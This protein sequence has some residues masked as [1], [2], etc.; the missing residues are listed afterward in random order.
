MPSV[1][2]PTAPNGQAPPPHTNG[3]GATTLSDD[4]VARLIVL[5]GIERVRR[6]LTEFE[7]PTLPLA[8]EAVEFTS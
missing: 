4:D 5:A 7:Q 8:A 1:S 3:N 6:V 2:N